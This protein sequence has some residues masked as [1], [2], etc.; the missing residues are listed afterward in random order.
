M[1]AFRIIRN[2]KNAYLVHTMPVHSKLYKE[3]SDGFQKFFDS[4]TQQYCD[5]QLYCNID[6]L[7]AV[8]NYIY[9]DLGTCV[10]GNNRHYKTIAGAK[11]YILN[12]K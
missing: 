11:K 9:N 2:T 6:S 7:D 10:F 8:L 12:N 3:L 5:Y 1:K 4:K